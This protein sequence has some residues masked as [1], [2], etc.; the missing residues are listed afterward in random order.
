MVFIV[1]R[2]IYDLIFLIMLCCGTECYL[3]VTK[4]GEGVVQNRLV[5]LT[6]RNMD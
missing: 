1:F 5:S 3:D 2:G 4:E 6:I